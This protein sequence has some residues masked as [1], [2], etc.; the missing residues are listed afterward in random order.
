M[1]GANADSDH[2]MNWEDFFGLYFYFLNI[3][4]N[5]S[6]FFLW[7]FTC[8]F[9]FHLILDDRNNV[10]FIVCIPTVNLNI[11]L[12]YT[13]KIMFRNSK[14]NL[15]YHFDREFPEA[16]TGLCNISPYGATILVLHMQSRR[17][18]S[19]VHVRFIKRDQSFKKK[20]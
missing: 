1:D 20:K 3:N 13:I 6:D 18:H 15:D 8:F 5:F 14:C 4:L 16:R 19:M 9:N 7:F 10:I 11:G 17:R 2:S 12:C